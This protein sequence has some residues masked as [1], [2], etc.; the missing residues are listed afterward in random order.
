MVV[1]AAAAGVVQACVKCIT[2]REITTREEGDLYRER[3]SKE[4][5]GSTRWSEKE[6]DYSNIDTPF[7]RAAAAELRSQHSDEN[8]SASS[9]FFYSFVFTCPSI[10]LV[11]EIGQKKEKSQRPAFTLAPVYRLDG[12]TTWWLF[13]LFRLLVRLN[14]LWSHHPAGSNRPESSFSRLSYTYICDVAWLLLSAFPECFHSRV[15]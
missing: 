15:L 10:R 2:G 13:F 11:R 1:V 5:W 4:E 9:S 8:L 6:E 14:T 3:E 12:L 7:S